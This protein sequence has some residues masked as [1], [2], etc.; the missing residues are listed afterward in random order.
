M[1]NLLQDVYTYRLRAPGWAAGPIFLAA[2][3][4]LVFTGALVLDGDLVVSGLGALCLV[5]GAVIASNFEGFD[6]A[7]KSRRFI[8]WSRKL[9]T[10]KETSYQLSQSC[11]LS[12]SSRLAEHHVCLCSADHDPVELYRYS[13]A[14]RARALGQKIAKVL[15]TEFREPTVEVG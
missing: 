15:R 8:K 9:G 7:P 3:F 4:A 11:W 5:T 12:V 1:A 10:R 13:D 6:Y 2:G 14:H